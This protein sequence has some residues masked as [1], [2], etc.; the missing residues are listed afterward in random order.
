[1][2]RE[3]LTLSHPFRDAVP[4]APHALVYLAD[5]KKAPVMLSAA[6]H[7]FLLAETKTKADPLLYSG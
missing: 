4:K 5:K 2:E 7:L 3:E 1:M 6:K